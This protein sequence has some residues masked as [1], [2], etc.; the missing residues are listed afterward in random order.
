MMGNNLLRHGHRQGIPL[1]K[2]DT[3]KNRRVEESSLVAS[4]TILRNGD[5]I[6]N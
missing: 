4:A 5:L 3:K 1:E 6:M 2:S